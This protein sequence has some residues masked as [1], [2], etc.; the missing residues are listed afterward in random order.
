MR[1]KAMMSNMIA[2]PLAFAYSEAM[3][4]DDEGGAEF[5]I[6]IGPIYISIS[7]GF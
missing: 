4:G 7:W 1:F 6:I 5:A 2:L 3:P